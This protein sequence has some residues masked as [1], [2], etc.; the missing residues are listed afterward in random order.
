MNIRKIFNYE[1]CLCGS[2]ISTMDFRSSNPIPVGY[3]S[4]TLPTPRELRWRW[5]RWSSSNWPLRVPSCTPLC[6]SVEKIWESLLSLNLDF[7]LFRREKNGWVPLWSDIWMKLYE[8]IIIHNHAKLHSQSN[9]LLK[10]VV[11]TTLKLFEKR[12]ALIQ[13]IKFV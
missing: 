4:L 6:T 10:W 1:T 13:K 7:N 9:L 5:S 3:F 8:I 2:N 12:N 11:K